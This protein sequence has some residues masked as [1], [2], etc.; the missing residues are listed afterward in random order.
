MLSNNVM[1]IQYAPA[2]IPTAFNLM[3]VKFHCMSPIDTQQF[4]YTLGMVQCYLHDQQL[5]NGTL[6]TL[7][8]EYTAF[9]ST[10]LVFESRTDTTI[11]A[12]EHSASGKGIQLHH[13]EYLTI[14]IK[15]LSKVCSLLAA[16]GYKAF[17]GA[18]DLSETKIAIYQVVFLM[19]DDRIQMEYK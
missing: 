17:I 6:T 16:K 7:A 2:Y 1:L 9:P 14:Y 5:K 15:N 12:L 11:A 18:M 4:Y 8:L 13:P 3:Y 10:R 19:G